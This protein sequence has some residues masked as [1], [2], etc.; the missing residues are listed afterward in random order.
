M[1]SHVLLAGTFLGFA[2]NKANPKLCVWYFWRQPPT[3]LTLWSHLTEK[4][5]FLCLLC[6]GKSSC[7]TSMLHN[8]DGSCSSGSMVFP[9]PPKGPPALLPPPAAAAPTSIP[10]LPE[11][12]VSWAAPGLHPK[13]RG[14]CGAFMIPSARLC[15]GSL[16][17]GSAARLTPALC[18]DGCP[19]W[20]RRMRTACPCSLPGARLRWPELRCPHERT[21]SKPALKLSLGLNCPVTTQRAV[22]PCAA[23]SAPV[24]APGKAQNGTAWQGWHD[25]AQHNKHGTTQ[26]NKARQSPLL[27]STHTLR[28]SPE[29]LSDAQG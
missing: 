28:M 24:R 9:G 20:T 11:F 14:S 16:V 27:P 21:A 12:G 19:A 5:A 4:R 29:P 1:P 8:R 7:P 26:S 18:Q 23:C 6:S 15:L 3:P 2:K 10:R 22:E 17:L 25:M 13:P